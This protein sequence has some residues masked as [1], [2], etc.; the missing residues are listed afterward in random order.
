MVSGGLLQTPSMIALESD[1]S[2]YSHGC[3]VDFS[4]KYVDDWI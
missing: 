1:E 3:G 4:L 2:N